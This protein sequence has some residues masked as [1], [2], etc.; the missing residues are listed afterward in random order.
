MLGQVTSGA[1]ACWQGGFAN[2]VFPQFDLGFNERSPR[3]TTDSL[4]SITA[5]SMLRRVWDD[6][7]GMCLLG[8]MLE[9]DTKAA[10]L[11]PPAIEAITG[12]EDFTW[13][14]TLE[15][16]HRVITLERIFNMKRGLTIE[17]DMDIGQRLME[18][19]EEGPAK[20]QT[21]TPH[22]RGLIKTDAGDAREAGP[23]RGGEGTIGTLHSFAWQ[24]HGVEGEEGRATSERSRGS[25]RA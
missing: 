4:A 11:I 18:P 5:K 24:R 3:F 8:G 10:Y 12:W 15:V 17:S 20:G 1:G 22:L 9:N 25:A 16:A 23:D 13:D 21:V 2:D 6:C 19:P 7:Y 14:E